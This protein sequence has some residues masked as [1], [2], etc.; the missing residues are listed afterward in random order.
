MNIE[1]PPNSTPPR[2]KQEKNTLEH[3]LLRARS[4]LPASVDV[5]T[6]K[7][8]NKKAGEE[9][10]ISSNTNGSDRLTK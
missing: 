3:L 6:R 1:I 5:S 8:A 2:E 10:I 7:M 9:A 4:I